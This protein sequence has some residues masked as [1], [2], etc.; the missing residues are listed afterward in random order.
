MFIEQPANKKSLSK[1]TPIFG[2]GINDA[3]YN[4]SVNINGKRVTCPFY[5]KWKGMMDRCYS[6]K[7]QERSPTYKGCSVCDEWLIFTKFKKWMLNKDWQGKELDKDII[8]QDNK[9]YSPDLCLFVS[10]EINLLLTDNAAARGLYPKG[11]STTRNGNFRSTCK[12]G[13][14]K[15]HIGVFDTVESANQAYI[16]FKKEHICSIASKQSEP[17]KGYLLAAAMVFK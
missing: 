15:K 7:T 2:I 10:C 14:R 12:V 8:K 11:V 9:I 3:S 16:D 6:T 17:L 13:G 1:R 5:I 4:I